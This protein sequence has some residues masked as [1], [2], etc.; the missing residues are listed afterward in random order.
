MA[1]YDLRK[2]A[3]CGSANHA[4]RQHAKMA[5]GDICWFLRRNR[6]RR[7]LSKKELNYLKKSLNRLL[8]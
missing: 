5:L 1:V 7:D 6:A 4:S 3:R 2:C 8:K